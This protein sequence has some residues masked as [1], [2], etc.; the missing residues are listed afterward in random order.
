LDIRDKHKLLVPLARVTAV[1]DAVLEDE[2][3]HTTKG[4]TWGTI[5]EALPITI[6][7]PA[8]TKMKIKEY[9]YL[10][11]EV[12]LD[13]RSAVKTLSVADTL[14]TFSKVTLSTIEAMEDFFSRTS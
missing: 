8:K 1:V 10:A 9:G 6:P 5:S 2:A 12:T 14:H 7:I 11:F 3:G 4:A 13:Q